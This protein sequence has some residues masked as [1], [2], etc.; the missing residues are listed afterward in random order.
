MNAFE[1]ASMVETRGMARL[2]PY[3][4]ERSY[5]G[6]FVRT[7][8]GPLA[9]FVQEELGDVIVNVNEDKIFAAEIKIE[10]RHT[11]NLFLETWS[12]RNLDSQS[13]HASRGCNPG[14][15]LKLRADCLLYY[16]L[17]TDDLY[18]IPL[19]RL[20]RWA[21]GSRTMNARLY[22]FPE[23]SQGKYNQMNETVGRIVP[24]HIIRKEVGLKHTKVQQLS[25]MDDAA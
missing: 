21:F 1:S 17:D 18:S 15:L 22:D 3:I 14:W 9:R 2:L 16:F 20:K 10:Q 23:L 11:G 13:E 25:L 8:K 4:E 12:N 19:F 6:R 7:C 24:I 5:E